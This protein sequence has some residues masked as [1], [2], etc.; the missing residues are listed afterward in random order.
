MKN[1]NLLLL[2]ELSPNPYGLSKLFYKK[3]SS[4]KIDA[5]QSLKPFR[6]IILVWQTFLRKSQAKIVG[7]LNLGRQ[8]MGIR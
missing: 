6:R 1:S 2:F 4:N 7:C 5:Q 3:S 8:T